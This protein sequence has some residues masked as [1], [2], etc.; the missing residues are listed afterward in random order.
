MAVRV[1]MDAVDVTR[2]QY[3]RNVE[4]VHAALRSYDL[5]GFTEVLRFLPAALERVCEF[6]KASKWGRG[7]QENFGMASVKTDVTLHDDP[8]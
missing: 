8:A 3:G 4:E 1:E 2:V 6:S 7:K 5:I